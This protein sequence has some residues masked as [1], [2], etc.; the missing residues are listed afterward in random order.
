MPRQSQT[1]STAGDAPSLHARRNVP[2]GSEQMTPDVSTGPEMPG[3]GDDWMVRRPGPRERRWFLL[4]GLMRG[5]FWLVPFLIVA[6]LWIFWFEVS[7]TDY[8]PAGI[9]LVGVLMLILHIFWGVLFPKSWL[10]SIGP[11]EVMVERGIVW[12]TRIFVPY[13]RVQQ[14]DRS[15]TP[16]MSS[17]DL[18]ELVL[19]SAAGGVRIYA[20]DPADADVI[21][22]RVR[23]QQ[24]ATTATMQ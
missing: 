15:S 9:L 2:V 3:M 4:H 16:V 17:L 11:H 24:P 22:E 10:V 20:L 5:L 7:I 23:V 8:V 19:H 14:I 21:A 12:L 6:I 1:D 13:D 18:T